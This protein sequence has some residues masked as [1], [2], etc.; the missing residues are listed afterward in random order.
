V[1]TVNAN[2]VLPCEPPGLVTVTVPPPVELLLVVRVK[3]VEPV[4]PVVSFA[5]MV[6]LA[7]PAVVGV[8]VIRP[9]VLIERPACRPVAL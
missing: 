9:E 7:V 4:A 2:E 6:T 5:V 3:V 8:P 1:Y